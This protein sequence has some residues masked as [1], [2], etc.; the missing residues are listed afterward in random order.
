VDLREAK[1]APGVTEIHAVLVAH[2]DDRPLDP[3]TAARY[4]ALS[5]GKWQA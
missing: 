4:A 2:L 1:L 3:D 5:S